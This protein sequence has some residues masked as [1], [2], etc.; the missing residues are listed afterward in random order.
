M[1]KMG[2]RRIVQ[3][4]RTANNP[5]EPQVPMVGTIYANLIV[6]PVQ[7]RSTS[8]FDLAPLGLGMPIMR[9]GFITDTD[10]LPTA[11]QG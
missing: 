2:T 10:F 1:A 11:E 5:P 8:T 6:S 4:R 3:G 9:E 7:I